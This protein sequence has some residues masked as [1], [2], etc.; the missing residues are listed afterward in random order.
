MRIYRLAAFKEK[1]QRYNIDD[2]FL[3]FFIQKYENLIPWNKIKSSEDIN[4]HISSSLLPD[5]QR[6]ID[7]KSD[8]NRYLKEIDLEAEFNQNPG[9]PQVQQAWAIYQQ[10]PEKA[11]ESIL[12]A[13]NGQKQRIFDSWWSY[14]T[15]G[16]DVYAQTP[17]FAYTVLKPIFDKSKANNKRS[18]MPLNEM[19]VAALYEKVRNGGGT[20]QFRIDKQYMNEVNVA[21]QQSTEVVPGTKMKDGN[22]WIRLP[23]Q[24]NDPSN[25][26]DNVNKLVGYSVPNGWCTGSGMAVPYLTKGDFYLYILDGK[27]EVAIRMDGGR[28]AEIQGERNRAPFA[29]TEEIEEFLNAKGIDPGNDYHYAELMEAKK[30]NDNLLDPQ[31]YK[32]FVEQITKEPRLIDRLSKENRQNPEVVQDIVKAIDVG[33]RK[34]EKGR[35]YFQLNNEV[36]YYSELPQDIR[37]QVLPETLDFVTQSV[38]ISLRVP[39]ENGKLRNNFFREIDHLPKEILEDVEVNETIRRTLEEIVQTEPWKMYNLKDETLATFPDD[40]IEKAKKHPFSQAI[41]KLKQSEG[42]TNPESILAEE[43]REPQEDDYRRSYWRGDENEETDYAVD[44]EAWE[45]NNTLLE[46]IGESDIRG[47]QEVKDALDNAWMKYI[48]TDPTKYE[49]DA[50]YDQSEYTQY[51]VEESEGYPGDQEQIREMVENIWW[52]KI[53][54][55]P[56]EMDYAPD[57]FRDNY[58]ETPYDEQDRERHFTGIWLNYFLKGNWESMLTH[59][60]KAAIEEMSP[61]QLQR[62]VQGIVASDVDVDFKE[63]PPNVQALLYNYE[64]RAKRMQGEKSLKD[65]GQQNLPFFDEMPTNEYTINERGQVVPVYPQQ[66]SVMSWYKYAKRIDSLRH[67][68]V[69]A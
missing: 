3:T 43:W 10:D 13:I 64:E 42:D 22:G 26:Q 66:A 34:Q 4:A 32:K 46:P 40:I 12:E 2:P 7:P 63:M 1:V 60:G 25:F 15:S 38:L 45:K 11:Q 19:A 27:A 23:S 30:L 52:E 35:H 54:E 28:L 55:D 37:V 44:H 31:K 61:E 68:F 39:N 47:I 36:G 69:N 18:T 17:A 57:N 56:T 24:Q 20:E 9:D 51:Y 41:E 49:T 50:M 59:D 5:L 16:N 48:E 29:Y 58:Y 65:Q 67:L 62:L 6:S 53:A 14:F 8:S 21:N 33:I